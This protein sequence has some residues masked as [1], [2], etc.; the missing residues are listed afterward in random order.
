MTDQ[1]ASQPFYAGRMYRLLTA[2]FGLFLT[3][4]GFY[5]FLF[6][7]TSPVVRLLGGSVL[8]MLGYNMVSSACQA[9]ESWLSRLGPLP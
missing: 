5:V 7:D 9:K 6:A 4:V 8:V 3:G 2:V 1:R